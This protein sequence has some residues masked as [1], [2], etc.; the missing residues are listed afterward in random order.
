MSSDDDRARSFTERHFPEIARFLAAERGEGPAPVFGPG[1][2]QN[3]HDDQP[4]PHVVVR[5]AYR[6]SRIELFAAFTAGYAMTNVGQDPDSMTVEQIRYD[7]E[8]HLADSSVLM[9]DD[10]VTDV[11]GKLQRGE[12][13]ERMQALKRA[14]DRAYPVGPPAPQPTQNPVY[15]DGWVT[16]DTLDYGR[17]TML[18][19][20]WCEGHDH[21]TV[22][23]RVD[24]AHFGA[25]TAAEFD[26]V[27]FL[28][29][30]FSQAPCSTAQPEVM[31]DVDEFPGMGPDELRA[32]AAAVGAHSGVLYSKANELD[33]IRRRQ[34]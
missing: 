14:V 22:Q 25:E 28:P 1:D 13:A 20:A 21:L 5:V 3:A 11:A 18:E 24:T 19:P 29:V 12:D 32:L 2:L 4:E 26:G 30:R 9:L 6:L 16:V 34:A 23:A 33:R 15:G 7:V 8:G 10:L 31:G 27:E 17:I